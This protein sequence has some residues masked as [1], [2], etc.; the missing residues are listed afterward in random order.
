LT[1]AHGTSAEGMMRAINGRLMAD[2]VEK[3]ENGDAL[4]NQRNEFVTFACPKLPL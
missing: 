3:V 1:S 4:K 2:S